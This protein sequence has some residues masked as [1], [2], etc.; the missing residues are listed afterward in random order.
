MRTDSVTPD[1]AA[2]AQ[3]DDGGP[4]FSLAGSPDYSYPPSDGMSL[5]DWF[6]G[7]ALRGKLVKPGCYETYMAYAEEVYKFADAMITARQ[8]NSSS[9]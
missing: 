9:T 8:Q 7:M 1:N 2:G 6:A 3:L 4:A 5:R